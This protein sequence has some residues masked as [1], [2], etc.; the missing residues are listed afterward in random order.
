MMTVSQASTQPVRSPGAGGRE[1]SGYALRGVLALVIAALVLITL[2]HADQV[3]FGP[4]PVGLSIVAAGSVAV[5]PGSPAP[6]AV[7]CIVLLLYGTSVPEFGVA[8]VGVAALLHAGHVLA[9]LAE[10]VP[11]RA[12]I[13]L[14]AL[15]STVRRWGRVQLLLVTPL[16]ILA[17]LL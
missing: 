9:G 14:P 6:M 4:V 8:A 17:L 2:V 3:G 10:V 16:V 11:S 7:S 5:F 15:R 12:R 13:E 1:I